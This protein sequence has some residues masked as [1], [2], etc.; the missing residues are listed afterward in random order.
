MASSDSST[1]AGG[2]GGCAAE[3]V[4]ELDENGTAAPGAGAG[5]GTAA[6]AGRGATG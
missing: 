6:G 5:V 3:R 1:T 4:G 2:A